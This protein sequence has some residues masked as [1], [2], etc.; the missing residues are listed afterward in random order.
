LFIKDYDNKL[1]LQTQEVQ[2]IVKSKFKQLQETG[3]EA[4][5]YF[6]SNYK[7][8]SIF[9]NGLLQ[10]ARLWGDGYDF[11]IQLGQ[12]FVLAEIKGVRNKNGAIRIT[13][14]E[15]NK[16]EEYKN[17]YFIIVVSNLSKTP[18]LNVIENP[19]ENLNFNRKEMNSIQI[20]YHT[21]HINW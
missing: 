7:T 4:E 17:D 8:I 19:L 15:F 20:N 5:F 12:K 13:Q 14:N 10:D 18:Q 21:E 6:M 9:E 3:N 2:P 11:Q 1:I 16:A